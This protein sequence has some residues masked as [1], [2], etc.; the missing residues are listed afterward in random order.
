MSVSLHHGAGLYDATASQK[1]EVEAEAETLGCV[2]SGHVG[3]SQAPG[4]TE[5][6]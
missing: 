6:L 1:M 2:G 3:V 5:E 4:Y